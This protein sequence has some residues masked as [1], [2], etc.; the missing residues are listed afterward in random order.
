MAVRAIM[1]LFL[2]VGSLAQPMR[3]CCEALNGARG[4]CCERA[5]G[6]FDPCCNRPRRMCCDVDGRELSRCCRETPESIC[7]GG[8]PPSPPTPPQVPIGPY[9]CLYGNQYV[10]LSV[11]CAAATP[12]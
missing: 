7:C 10:P 9:S 5:R 11:C 4:Q 2:M 1:L 6:R 12:P 3:N 8:V